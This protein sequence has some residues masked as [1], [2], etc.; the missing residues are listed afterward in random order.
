MEAREGEQ[1]KIYKNV[2]QIDKNIQRKERNEK[3]DG[4]R[5]I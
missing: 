1:G 5:K 3:Q 4:I 2:K